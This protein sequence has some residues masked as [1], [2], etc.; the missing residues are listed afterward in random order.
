MSN[1]KS[2]SFSYKLKNTS[3]ND[4][5][6]DAHVN[7]WNVP[8]FR[9]KPF[10][11][12]GL[13][14][15]NY[16]CLE[17]ICF[18]APFE[19]GNDDLSDLSYQLKENEIQLIFNNINYNYKKIPDT[20]FTGFDDDKQNTVVIL[21]IK[22]SNNNP[23]NY[24]SIESNSEGHLIFKIDFLKVHN[25]PQEV[26]SIYIRF[27]L[28]NIDSKL[29]LSTLAKKNN[30]LESAFTERQI[31]DFKLNNV[32]TMDRYK[33]EELKN[34]GF[35][36]AKFRSIHL[37]LMVPSDYEV[38]IWGGFSECRKLEANEWN[39]YLN[40]VKNILLKGK[41]NK[42]ENDISAY[43]WKQKSEENVDE[44]AQLIK[45]EHKA[46]KPLLIFIYCLIVIVLGSLGSFL[47]EITKNYMGLY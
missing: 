21:P 27:R 47:F 8:V 26:N 10:I 34:E 39:N 30:Y 43:H 45:M 25:V 7:V 9:G 31:L 11:D 40:D 4:V 44:F 32:R 38:S 19:V 33:F 14:V 28:K 23:I 20:I 36:L 6:F 46:T 41:I 29:L 42:K 2:F 35:I 5:T 24:V 13:L 3:E 16:R 22:E 18:S 17:S 12:F 37:F 1:Q 15:N